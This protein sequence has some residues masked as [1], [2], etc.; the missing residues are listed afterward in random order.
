MQVQPEE[1]SVC[2]GSYLGGATGDQCIE[3][4]GTEVYMIG[5]SANVRAATRVKP[6]QASKA[7]M[8]GSSRPDNGEDQWRP[9]GRTEAP[10]RPR[11][12]IGRSTYRRHTRQR[13][14]SAVVFPAGRQRHVRWRPAQKSEEPIVARKPGNAGG[15]KGPHFRDADR[16]SPGEVIDDESGNADKNPGVSE[17]AIHESEAGA[18]LPVLPAL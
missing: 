15:A 5:R 13:G 18:Q 3:A 7:V 9:G 6:E 1:L 12:G 14:R 2:L 8:R 16:R 4:P 10:G 17:A 11:R